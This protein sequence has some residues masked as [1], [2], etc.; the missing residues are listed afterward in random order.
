MVT[1]I[2]IFPVVIPGP[3]GA[4]LRAPQH[5]GWTMHGFTLIELMVVVA[6]LAILIT[7][8]A[9]GFRELVAGQRIKNAS[10]DVFSSMVQ[11]RSEAIT[12][13]TTVTVTPAA[14]GWADGWTVTFV[15]AN[16]TVTVVRR[17]DAYPNITITSLATSVGFNGMGRLTGAA[18][19]SLT[20][21][22]ASAAN[23]RC[24][25]LDLSGRPVSKTGACS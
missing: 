10:F 11:A 5:G 24:I 3:S 13:N 2:P 15:A 1:A 4:G 25:T 6:V 17:Q 18:S 20:A 23:Y 12:R 16:G 19:F 7:V 22:G 14:G 8:A 9:P 21:T